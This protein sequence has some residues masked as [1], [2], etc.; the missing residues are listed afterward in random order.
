MFTIA[1][2]LLF[3]VKKILLWKSA[4]FPAV[5]ARAQGPW[6]PWKRIS[7]HWVV[8]SFRAAVER[9][10]Q[11][12]TMRFLLPFKIR[13]RGKKHVDCEQDEKHTIL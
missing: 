10:S 4:A 7:S 11:F 5:C 9:I 13:R 8:L 12:N 6:L 2:E 3:L 1:M